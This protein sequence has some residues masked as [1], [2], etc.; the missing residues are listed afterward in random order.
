MPALEDHKFFAYTF[1]M[2]TRAM[3]VFYGYDQ[4]SVT[5]AF[6]ALAA[7]ALVVR[8]GESRSLLLLP[9]AAECVLVASILSSARVGMVAFVVGSAAM[10][11]L[12][13]RQINKYVSLGIVAAMLTVALSGSSALFPQSKTIERNLDAL[14]TVVPGV[15]TGGG[16]EADGISVIIQT[17]IMGI[18]FPTGLDSF[19]GYGDDLSFVSDVGYVSTYV[20]YGIAG[21]LVVIFAYVSWIRTAGLARA[22]SLIGGTFTHASTYIVEGAVALFAVAAFKGTF[23]FLTQKTGDLVAVVL[24]VMLYEYLAGLRLREQKP[25]DFAWAPR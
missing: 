17:Q 3:S 8:P 19:F 11:Y 6:G 24:G 23:Y 12:L 20:K 16:D 9:V 4:A 13:R 18:D 10:L 5:Y 21:L 15:G 25:Q 2:S 1:N 14:Q 7:I 22:A